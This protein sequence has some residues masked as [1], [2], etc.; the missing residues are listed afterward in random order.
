MTA[1]DVRIA[2]IATGGVDPFQVWL[3]KARLR[4]NTPPFT[5][6]EI[7]ADPGLK[8]IAESIELFRVHC[9]VIVEHLARLYDE[10]HGQL[11]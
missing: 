2:P 10:I 9:R 4:F 5:D 1:D 6:A 11:C 3:A 7:E 8:E